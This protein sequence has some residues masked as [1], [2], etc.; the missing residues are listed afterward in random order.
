VKI[1]LIKRKKDGHFLGKEYEEGYSYSSYTYEDAS[2]TSMYEPLSKY[3]TD[4]ND[5]WK[6]TLFETKEA[7]QDHINNIHGKTSWHGDTT[8]EYEV[9]LVKD[10]ND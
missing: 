6:L 1:A 3:T 8:E 9:V 4:E 5:E 2:W 10:I 7:A